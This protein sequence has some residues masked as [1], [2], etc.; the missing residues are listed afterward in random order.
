MALGHAAGEEVGAGRVRADEALA[1][2]RTSVLRIFRPG[3]GG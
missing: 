2:L 1:V 3:A